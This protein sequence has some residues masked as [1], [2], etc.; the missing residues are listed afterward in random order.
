MPCACV[1]MIAVKDRSWAGRCEHVKV[2]W[3]G[4]GATVLV[5]GSHVLQHIAAKVAVNCNSHIAIPVIIM[6]CR[7]AAQASKASPGYL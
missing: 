5:G 7:L 3:W 2:V 6:G 1:Y 4:V